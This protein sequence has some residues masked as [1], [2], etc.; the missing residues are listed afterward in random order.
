MV[1]LAFSLCGRAS[2]LLRN[3]LGPAI[4]FHSGAPSRRSGGRSSQRP[5][6][7][8]VRGLTR[9]R[10]DHPG[11]AVRKQRQGLAATQY[12]VPPPRVRLQSGNDAA[13][14]YT[15]RLPRYTLVERGGPVRSRSPGPPRIGPAATRRV[16]GSR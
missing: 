15:I 10:R 9:S 1:P 4:I 11:G 7:P 6:F 13:W 2:R 5:I 3:R 12:L 8:V 14:G 16:G